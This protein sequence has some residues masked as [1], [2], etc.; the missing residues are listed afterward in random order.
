MQLRLGEQTKWTHGLQL[1]HGVFQVDILERGAFEVLQ[2]I[3][4]W[5]N[6]LVPINKIPP[7]ILA[8]IPDFWDTHKRDQDTIA[9]THVCRTWRE[10]FVSRTSL[11]TRFDCLNGEKTRTYLERSKSSPIDLS[12]TGTQDMSPDDPLFQIIPHAIGR[13]RSLS[14]TGFPEDVQDIASHLSYPAPLLEDLS[15]RCRESHHYPA[16]PS[17]FFNGDLSSLRTLCLRF[18]RTELPWRNMVNLTSFTLSPTSPRTASVEQLLDFFNSAPHLEQVN[19]YSAT[20]TAGAQNGRVVSL[21]CLKSMYI[22]GDDP[23]SVLLNHLLIPVGTKLEIRAPLLSSLIGEHLPRSLDNLKNFSDFTTIRVRYGESSYPRMKF[24]GPNGQ[25]NMTLEIYRDDPTGFTLGA[26]AELDTSKTE[27]LRIDGGYL[28]SWDPLYRALLPMK[29]LRTLTLARCN[30]PD[31]FICALQPA[32]GSSE[33]V[34]CPKLEELVLALK[35]YETMSH[36]TN[37]TK[38]A[39]ARASKGEKLGTVRIVDGWDAANFD[40][41]ELRKHVW[42]VECGPGIFL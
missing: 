31:T 13:L 27:L 32:T 30:S 41:S 39:A 7:E 40:V 6:M 1:I 9:L 4:V 12:L 33:V 35:C 42:N 15:I 3:R 24:I 14:M 21:T 25:V 37:V 22:E 2:L 11:W 38:I 36:I 17:T 5:K 8:L 16:L 18:V 28:R 29:N 19:L 23:P 26:L 34:I 20:S 10:V